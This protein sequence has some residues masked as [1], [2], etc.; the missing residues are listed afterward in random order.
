MLH[1]RAYNKNKHEP[2]KAMTV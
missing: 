1:A 2:S